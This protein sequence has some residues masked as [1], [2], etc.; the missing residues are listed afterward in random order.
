MKYISYEIVY[1]QTEIMCKFFY[2]PKP[3]LTMPL[4]SYRIKNV[5]NDK[6]KTTE[7]KKPHGLQVVYDP[8]KCTSVKGDMDQLA[9]IKPRS[10]PNIK[11]TYLGL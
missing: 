1:Y 10:H 3:S 4:K 9:S 8:S 5:F 2:K 6:H 11:Y 7:K